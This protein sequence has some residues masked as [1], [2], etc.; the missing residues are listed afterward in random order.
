MKIDDLKC[1]GNCKFCGSR[2]IEYAKNS[3]F[4]DWSY[5]C[6]PTPEADV[7]YPWARCELWEF[8]GKTKEYR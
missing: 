2:Q 3:S 1:C 5:C 4:T 8:D 6:H 7:A